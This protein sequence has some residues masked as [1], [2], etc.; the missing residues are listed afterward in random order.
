MGFLVLY[1]IVMLCFVEVV[2][3]CV[4]LVDYRFVLEVF[5]LVVV[6][7]GVVVYVWLFKNG[8]LVRVFGDFVGGGF[9]I[10]VFVLV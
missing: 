1:C 5:F 3:C 7:D 6:E 4:F 2:W 9:I 10:V 8:F